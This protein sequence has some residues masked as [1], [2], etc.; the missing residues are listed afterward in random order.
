MISLEISP[1]RFRVRFTLAGAREPSFT[2]G[3]PDEKIDTPREAR[4]PVGDRPRRSAS[5][6]INRSSDDG[7][8]FDR[9]T[10]LSIDRGKG[11][12]T[13][14][15]RDAKRR[16]VVEVPREAE[17]PDFRSGGSGRIQAWLGRTLRASSSWRRDVT[18]FDFDNHYASLY[19]QEAATYDRKRFTSHKGR[20]DRD[21]KNAVIVDI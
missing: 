10:L 19:N 12:G 5:S 8:S 2:S 7:P 3:S 11:L 1:P 6:Q 9:E 20:F 13:N 21:F 4:R 16:R 15:S 18:Q 14:S 17:A